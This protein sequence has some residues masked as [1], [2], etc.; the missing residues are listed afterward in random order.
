MLYSSAQGW[1]NKHLLSKLLLDSPFLTHLLIYFTHQLNN[2]N[3]LAKP[4]SLWNMYV[5]CCPSGEFRLWPLIH[6]FPK[7]RDSSIWIEDFFPKVHSPL[8]SIRE[9]VREEKRVNPHHFS[10]PLESSLAASFF[11]FLFSRVPITVWGR[12]KVGR[13][14]SHKVSGLKKWAEKKSVDFSIEI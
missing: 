14:K 8:L 5:L 11:F 6:S 7:I 12:G 9:R 10:S 3:G 1:G 13:R 2:G 4:P